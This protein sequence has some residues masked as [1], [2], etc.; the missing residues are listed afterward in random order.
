VF[1]LL[2]NSK[3]NNYKTQHFGQWT[4]S[5]IQTRGGR[6]L[7]CSVPQKELTSITAQPM[8]K[9]KLKLFCDWHSVG[10]SLFALGPGD[11]ILVERPPWGEDRSI[12]YSYSVTGPCQHCCCHYRVHIRQNS[13]PY[14]TISFETPIKGEDQVPIFISPRKRVAQLYP[15]ALFSLCRLLQLAGLWWRY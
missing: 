5:Y 1:V 7:L 12:I 2:G 9:F 11:F 8:L 15:W 3:W 13:W 10:R 4:C 6:H 14:L